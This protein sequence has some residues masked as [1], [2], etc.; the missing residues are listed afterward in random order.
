MQECSK[1][2]FDVRKEAFGLDL[3][4]APGEVPSAFVVKVEY[5]RRRKAWRASLERWPHNPNYGG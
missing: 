2:H 5:C 3:Y 4:W 1:Q